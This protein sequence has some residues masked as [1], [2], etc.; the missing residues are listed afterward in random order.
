MP[1]FFSVFF[2]LITLWTFW[3][4]ALRYKHIYWHV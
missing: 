3:L 4:L 2:Y 1:V